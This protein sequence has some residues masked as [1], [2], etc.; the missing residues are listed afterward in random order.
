MFD[1]TDIVADRLAKANA[2]IY[3]ERPPIESFS[4]KRVNTATQI[5]GY[6]FDYV[7]VARVRLHL[8]ESS[9]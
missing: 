4:D 7:L 2:G 6:F 1:Q 5:R 3:G 9:R 8:P